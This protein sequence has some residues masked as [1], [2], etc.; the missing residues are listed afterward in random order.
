M[1]DTKSTPFSKVWECNFRNH[2][3]Y[4]LRA[5]ASAEADLVVS[6]HKAPK[7]F[8]HS[9]DNLGGAPFKWWQ[10]APFG[11]LPVRLRDTM[12]KWI[13]PSALS[14]ARPGVE[15]NNNTNCLAL[16]FKCRL[17]FK[18][19]PWIILCANYSVKWSRD[20]WLSSSSSSLGSS[21]HCGCGTG[22]GM[23]LS[24]HKCVAGW[25]R[26]SRLELVFEP[27]VTFNLLF[28]INWIEL[29]FRC[30]IQT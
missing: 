22:P 14:T 18:R 11:N 21:S 24:V 9:R 20:R 16:P 2:L 5:E 4:C 29:T 12:G 19:S 6:P 3:L 27:K 28:H 15:D 23:N 7:N 10:A 30:T 26:F 13:I 8:L 25:V 17:Y 1:K